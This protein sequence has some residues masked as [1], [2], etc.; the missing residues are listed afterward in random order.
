MGKVKIGKFEVDEE[1]LDRE[2]EEATRRGQ[3]ALEK[4]PRAASAYYDRESGRIVVDLLNG[5]TFMFPTELAQGLR[6]AAPEDLAEVEVD[7]YG[8]TLHWER[9]DA[10]FTLA[11]LMA[12]I[13]GTRAWMEELRRK[14]GSVTSEAKVTASR[15]DGKRG[16]RP[17]QATRKRKSS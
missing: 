1:E 6:G 9:L 16:G 12:G 3:E 14:G 8:L 2:F 10:D 5:C 11:G 4:E 17:A 13:F 15:A 7:P